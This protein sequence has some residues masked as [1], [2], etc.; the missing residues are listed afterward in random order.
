V[1]QRQQL[2]QQL[3]AAT[4]FEE[5][6]MA[7]TKL[8][9]LE[10]NSVEQQKLRWKRETRLY[11]ELF[12]FRAFIFCMLALLGASCLLKAASPVCLA[13]PGCRCLLWCFML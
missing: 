7:A 8:D 10:G 13:S 1:Q 11:G 2:R 5:W 4:S 9:A 12:L 3:E 6:S